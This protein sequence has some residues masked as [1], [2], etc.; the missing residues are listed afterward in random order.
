[1]IKHFIGELL[2][3][4]EKGWLD[5]G[6]EWPQID[7]IR[8]CCLLLDIAGEALIMHVPADE[9]I[10][11]W[12]SLWSKLAKC[13][14]EYNGKE[15]WKCPFRS[16]SCDWHPRGYVP[17]TPGQILAEDRDIARECLRKLEHLESTYQ[18]TDT[19]LPVNGLFPSVL[20]DCLLAF[21]NQDLGNDKSSASTVNPELKA[22]STQ[23]LN[24]IFKLMNSVV[25]VNGG[26]TLIAQ[27]VEDIG[28]C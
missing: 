19:N 3:A 27:I 2:D 17:A 8:L 18:G 14:N 25:E 1:M 15:R 9:P 11:H 10:P 7:F 20:R 28:I 23:S 21:I 26:Y 6:E 24:I 13:I 4:L 5:H 12:A 22:V 16:Y